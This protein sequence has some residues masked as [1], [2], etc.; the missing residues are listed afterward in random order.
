MLALLQ[1]RNFGCI[2]FGGLI[3]L[4]GDWML[5]TALPVYVYQATGSTL[6]TGA[7]LAA[8]VI[9][10]VLL[11]SVAGVF[12][13]RW[14]RRQTLIV[15]NLLLGLGLL[16]LLLV[17]SDEKL[18]LV[19]LVSFV[20]SAVAQFVSPALGALLPNLVQKREL[21][22]ANS[23]IALSNDVSRLVGPPLGGIVVASTGLAGVALVDAASFAVVASMVALARVGRRPPK[24][25]MPAE[26]TS[27]AGKVWAVVAQQWLDG[28]ARVPR[29]RVLTVM[30]TFIAVSAV[31]EGVMGSLF[32]PF[33]S[34]VLGGDALAFGW[35]ISA[36]AIGGIL[37]SLVVSTRGRILSPAY[38]LGFG[39]LGLCLFDL[40][41]FNYHVIWPGIWPAMVFMAIVGAPIAGLVAGQTTLLQSATEDAYRGR[42]LGAFGAV[43][44]LSTF[45]GALLGGVLGDRV[46]IVTMLNI[47]GLGYGTAG[48]IVLIALRSRDIRTFRTEVLT[49][50]Y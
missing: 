28:L 35:I 50:G 37:G 26:P 47:Q 27:S 29:S 31:G 49:R 11:G 21:L 14:D 48:I 8:R 15:A 19:Y 46:G 16:P 32:P 41:T 17:T 22:R 38:L 1:Q 3:S 40:M 6:A 45:I 18:W 25:S 33:V 24:A 5:L 12:V 43:G 23:L 9:P 10:R 2:W 34:S 4:I 30:F 42:I 39:A 7:M 13:D 36:Q 20:Q 44:A